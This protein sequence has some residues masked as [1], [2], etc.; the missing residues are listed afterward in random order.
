MVQVYGN[1]L[2]LGGRVA[3]EKKSTKFEVDPELSC[4]VTKNGAIQ[5]NNNELI[6]SDRSE[7]G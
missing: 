7:S 4:T 5:R 1:N 6:E 3:L 2:K